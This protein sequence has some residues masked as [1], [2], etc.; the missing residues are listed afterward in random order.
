MALKQ[1]ALFFLMVL[2][3][4]S[5]F[6]ETIYPDRVEVHFEFE[7]PREID[8]GDGVRFAIPDDQVTR[9]EFTFVQEWT[10]NFE[11]DPIVHEVER[12]QDAQIIHEP[13]P[14]YEPEMIVGENDL[15]WDRF[16]DSADCFERQEQYRSNW[17]IDSDLA[18]I[19]YKHESSSYFL[20]KTRV[21]LTQRGVWQDF[22]YDCNLQQR[23]QFEK[24]ANQLN[25]L[26]QF[27]SEI[28][29][30][31]EL[32][33]LAENSTAFALFANS[34]NRMNQ[35][36]ASKTCLDISVQL[37]SCG[38]AVLTGVAK[39]LVRNVESIYQF[40]R[41]PIKTSGEILGLAGKVVKGL[42]QG[43]QAYN[44]MRV[45]TMSNDPN[46]LA[47][48]TVVAES[49]FTPFNL[50]NQNLQH[51]YNQA[52]PEQLCEL[53]GSLA[54]D[55]IFVIKGGQIVSIV[56]TKAAIPL[57]PLAKYKPNVMTKLGEVAQKAQSSAAQVYNKARQLLPGANEVEV[58]AGDVNLALDVEEL[59]QG[60][61]ILRQ[62]AQKIGE[63]V[64]LSA[65]AEFEAGVAELTVKYGTQ[66]IED[67]KKVLNF[68][69]NKVLKIGSEKL[70]KRLEAA[71]GEIAEITN[72]G[73]LHHA[74]YIYDAGHTGKPTW[75]SLSESRAACAAEKQSLYKKLMRS[76]EEKYDFLDEIGNRIDVKSLI[77]QH[78]EAPGS[79][80][81][82]TEYVGKLKNGIID[83]EHI[84]IDLSR[85]EKKHIDTLRHFLNDL[86]TEAEMNKI[87]FITY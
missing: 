75:G 73:E 79:D 72:C 6:S 49:F 54:V 39:G 22:E 63:A 64:K 78:I 41:H 17:Q 57:A 5:L 45:A 66:V 50:L 81:C 18:Q 27:R 44:Q 4:Q 87:K 24:I 12:I 56:A 68:H 69:E 82:F 42:V 46:L 84:L 52:T 59:A 80:F 43:V 53:V 19:T 7:G 21:F 71:C 26:I 34:A 38:M 20:P 11:S 77:S 85:A 51:F 35:I 40:A 10:P 48:A 65:L 23:I 31:F 1:I 86:L 28:G 37:L 47:E 32:K 70:L 29:S 76:L 33:N 3:F 13:E 2:N 36:G 62:D 16:H 30:F 74:Q 8:L 9:H 67:A 15:G 55:A 61:N 58:I 60:A 14:T 83:G 25:Q